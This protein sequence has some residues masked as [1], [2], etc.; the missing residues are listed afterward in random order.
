MGV[1]DQV[2]PAI[3]MLRN[4]LVLRASGS[5]ATSCT[6]SCCTCP[7][8]SALKA[9]SAWR[10]TT[11][12]GE[13]L[14]CGS[15]RRA[16]RSSRCWAAEPC[17]RWAF[18]WAGS[19][20]RPIR[21]RPPLAGRELRACLDEMCE[22]TLFLAEH[23]E[24]PCLGA[25]L[26]VRRPVSGRRIPHEPRPHPQQQGAERRPGGVRPSAME[27]RQVRIPPRCT[28]WSRTAAPTWSA[29]WRG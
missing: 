9:R 1:F 8:S 22:L 2:D 29:R 23:V 26:R 15:R 14:R 24:F 10:P 5:K 4:V 13:A 28:R 19:T 20:G 21:P 6:C 7:T 17:T 27:E 18:A 25:R 16:T 11:G 12:A 3:R